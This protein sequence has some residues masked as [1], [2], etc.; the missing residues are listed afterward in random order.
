MTR[1]IYSNERVYFVESVKENLRRKTGN[2]FNKKDMIAAAQR[3]RCV[4]AGVITATTEEKEEALAALGT[5]PAGMT[6][7]E[8][9]GLTGSCG[10][11]CPAWKSECEEP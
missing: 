6:T 1:E 2:R 3:I 5:Y 9:W 10:K 7:C 11:D 8:I 4:L